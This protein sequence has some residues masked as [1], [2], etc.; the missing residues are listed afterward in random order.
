KLAVLGSK[1]GN[2]TVSPFCE[3]DVE[4]LTRPYVFDNVKNLKV[5][6]DDSRVKWLLQNQ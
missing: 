3:Y 4:I 5:F 2:Y 6:D 1:F